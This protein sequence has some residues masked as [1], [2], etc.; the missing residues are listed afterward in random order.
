M[1][2]SIFSPAVRKQDLTSFNRFWIEQFIRDGVTQ[3]ELERRRQPLLK[4][5]EPDCTK[6]ESWPNSLAD[7]PSDCRTITREEINTFARTLLVNEHCVEIRVVP[8]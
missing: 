6:N 7:Y 2:K 3:D 1:V 8:Q 5:L 4:S